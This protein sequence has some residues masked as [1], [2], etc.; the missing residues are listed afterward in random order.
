MVGRRRRR[1]GGCGGGGG[2]RDRLHQTL[3][4]DRRTPV[5]QALVRGQ[6]VLGPVPPSAK[7]AHVQR[8]GPLVFVLEMPFQ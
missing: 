3:E 2:G 8:V 1:G 7:L 5:L 4:R 6:A